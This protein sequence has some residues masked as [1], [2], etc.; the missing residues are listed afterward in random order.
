MTNALRES[1]TL[2]FVAATWLVLQ[3]QWLSGSIEGTLVEYATVN[4]AV[5][6][7]WLGREWRKDHYANKPAN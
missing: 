6:A 2:K 5:L 7:I 3:Y 1:T 4:A